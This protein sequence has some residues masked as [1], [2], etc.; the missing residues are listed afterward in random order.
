M[1]LGCASETAHLRATGQ[2]TLVSRGIDRLIDAHRS[3]DGAGVSLTR[4]TQLAA[5][6]AL[7]PFV[8]LDEIH[9][10]N[11]NDYERGFPSHPH[12]GFETVSIM[13]DGRFRHRD[14]RGGG[15]VV[16]PGGAQWMTAGSGI[17]H[18]EMPETDGPSTELWGFQLWVNLPRA[19]KWTAPGYQELGAERMAEITLDR[20]GALR[21]IAGELLGGRGPVTPRATEPVLAT[22]H[23]SAGDDVE[24]HLPRDHNAFVLAADGSPAIGARRETIPEGALA[25]LSRGELLRI[26][27]DAPAQLLVLAGAPIGEPIAHGGPFVMNT[28]EE[29][30]QA[31][32]DYRAGRLG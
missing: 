7:D 1:A 31:F 23:M 19:D 11:P 29:I 27:A 5:L 10:T 8:L 25:Q 16:V 28:D 24:L 9:S 30:R 2:R 14:S 22:L 13:L 4:H 12:R 3:V 15:G 21:V 17:V 32:E 20:G 6:E 18:S 26:R